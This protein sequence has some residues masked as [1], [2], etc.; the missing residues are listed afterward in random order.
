MTIS[1]REIP[2]SP[3]SE[4]CQKPSIILLRTP[5]ISSVHSFSAP[6]TPPLAL[7]YLAASLIKVGHEVVAIDALGEAIDQIKVYSDPECR[8]RGLTIDEIISR[9][10]PRTQII[11]LSC[12]LLCM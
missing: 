3:L 12:M 10:S 6:V 4:A 2:V 1:F 8:V 7:A 9:I 5:V 11:A